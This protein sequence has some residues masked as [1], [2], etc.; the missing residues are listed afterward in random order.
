[1]DDLC[2]TR[3]ICSRLPPGTEIGNLRGVA[4]GQ[5]KVFAAM[6]RDDGV[7][8]AQHLIPDDTNEITQVRGLLDHVSRAGQSLPPMPPMPSTT[9]RNTTPGKEKETTTSESS[10]GHGRILRRSV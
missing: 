7:I 2:A 3:N 1:M 9:P 10:S 8:I 6:L 5:V 4:D